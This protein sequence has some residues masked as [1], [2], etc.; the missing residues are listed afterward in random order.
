MAGD[1]L[2]FLFLPSLLFLTRWGRETG[3]WGASALYYP[4]LRIPEELTIEKTKIQ[5]P[6]LYQYKFI[7]TGYYLQDIE[8]QRRHI[9]YSH[10]IRGVATLRALTAACR[11][12]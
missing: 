7:R 9:L 10:R 6:S 1:C 4:K 8:S 12:S 11:Q 2:V 5:A 3:G